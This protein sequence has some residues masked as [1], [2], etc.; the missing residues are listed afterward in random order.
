M[1]IGERDVRPAAVAEALRAGRLVLERLVRH[2][3]DRRRK[4]RAHELIRPGRVLTVAEQ[5]APGR[6]FHL[7]LL[8]RRDYKLALAVAD[9][10]CIVIISRIRIGPGVARSVERRTLLHRRA[11]LTLPQQSRHY[12]VRA[13]GDI[14]DRREIPSVSGDQRRLKRR[15]LGARIRSIIRID[16]LIGGHDQLPQIA[17]A[18]KGLCVRSRGVERRQQ[19]GDQHGHNADHDEQFD[20]SESAAVKPACPSD[21]NCRTLR[22]CASA[23][24]NLLS[25][26]GEGSISLAEA[27]RRRGWIRKAHWPAIPPHGLAV[28]QP[29]AR[30]L[31]RNRRPA[32]P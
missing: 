5:G 19:D 1:A 32:A 27:Q 15:I 21:Y 9:V 16:I 24:D 11:G 23:R 28:R 29:L 8:G 4:G 13:G 6:I 14:G 26:G 25:H 7:A 3:P 22:L 10:A 30:R 17:E 12:R 31:F 20:Q 18:L 2:A